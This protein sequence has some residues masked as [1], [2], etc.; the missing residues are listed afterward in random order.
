MKKT[1]NDITAEYYQLLTQ[2]DENDGVV[3]DDLL[4][5]LESIEAAFEDKVDRVL[6][7]AQTYDA[8]ADAES[9]RAK[10]IKAHSDALRNKAEN[11]RDWVHSKM[12]SLGHTSVSGS[13]Y[14]AKIEKNQDVV[15]LNEKFVDLCEARGVHDYL[16]FHV[17]YYTADK[18]KIKEALKSGEEIEGATLVTG[19]TRLKVS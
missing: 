14:T 6:S 19:R 16:K 9:V 4:D 1:L 12:R 10:K 5:E 13:N 15:E 8:K 17:A 18:N 2:V 11:L 3:D 7:V